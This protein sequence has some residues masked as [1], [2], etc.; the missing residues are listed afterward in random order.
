MLQDAEGGRTYPSGDNWK[1]LTEGS[2]MTTE[3]DTSLIVDFVRRL[4]RVALHPLSLDE[5]GLEDEMPLPG[6]Y[7]LKLTRAGGTATISANHHATIRSPLPDEVQFESLATRVRAFTLTNDRLFWS[8]VFDAL[9]RL[10][11]P[12][13]EQVCRWSEQFRQ[14][15]AKSTERNVPRERAYRLGYRVGDNDGAEER[16]FT[17]IDAAYAWLYQDVAHGDEVST[18]TSASSSGS[19]PP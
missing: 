14:A 12:E 5:S 18:A 19:Q 15:W 11:R 1:S 6:N 2:A 16:H 13:D 7:L 10:T 9:D 4:R 8:K 17:D 3:D